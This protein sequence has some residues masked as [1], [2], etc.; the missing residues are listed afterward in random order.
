MSS[1]EDSSHKSIDK[2]SDESSD[3][4]PD[5]D[6]DKAVF[7]FSDMSSSGNITK[8]RSRNGGTPVREV[9]QPAA[10]TNVDTDA[11]QK[12]SQEKQRTSKA[13]AE[14]WS[15]LEDTPLQKRKRVSFTEL[16][17][18]QNHPLSTTPNPNSG[19]QSGSEPTPK[20][21]QK[22]KRVSF[23]GIS[24]FPKRPLTPSKTPR[25]QKPKFTPQK[26]KPR[27]PTTVTTNA[28]ANPAA[29]TYPRLPS[30]PTY[31][32]DLPKPVEPE[33][34]DKQS[35]HDL[36]EE[37]NL[38][39]TRVQA[40]EKLDET[41]LAAAAPIGAIAFSEITDTQTIDPVRETLRTVDRPAAEAC[42]VL[43]DKLTE[44]QAGLAASRVEGMEQFIKFEEADE[45]ARRGKILMERIGLL[46][47]SNE[48]LGAEKDEL[49]RLCLSRHLTAQERGQYIRALVETNKRFK[50][51]QT[52]DKVTIA[53]LQG[54]INNLNRENHGLEQQRVAFVK[55]AEVY[56]KKLCREGG[57]TTITAAEPGST[58][59]SQS[60]GYH[61]ETKKAA[62]GLAKVMDQLSGNNYVDAI[63][64]DSPFVFLLDIVREYG[65]RGG[66]QI[67]PRTNV[68]KEPGSESES[69]SESESKSESESES[70]PKPKLK[71]EPKPEPKSFEPSELDATSLTNI[72]AD[73]PC[74]TIKL[75]LRARIQR[76]QR[77][78][79]AMT[80]S[81]D[82]LRRLN[83]LCNTSNIQA[84]AAYKAQTVELDKVMHTL[85]QRETEQTASIA[86]A[87]KLRGSLEKSRASNEKARKT[88]KRLLGLIERVRIPNKSDET[89]EENQT[90]QMRI[91]LSKSILENKSQD[92]T[93]LDLN[94][95]ITTLRGNLLFNTVDM[96]TKDDLI[97]GM[98]AENLK[99]EKNSAD[100]KALHAEIASLKGMGDECGKAK[101]QL[102][103]E[104]LELQKQ[105]A[106]QVRAL[107]A[108]MKNL[109]QKKN[110]SQIQAQMDVLLEAER[111]LLKLQNSR[112]DE[113]RAVISIWEGI[114]MSSEDLA[115]EQVRQLRDTSSKKDDQIKALEVEVEGLRSALPTRAAGGG[116]DPCAHIKKQ[117][118]E[119]QAASAKKD[120]VIKDLEAEVDKMRKTL[121]AGT[122]GDGTDPCAL[123]KKQ[124]LEA[125]AASA[126]KDDL[127]KNLQAEIHKVKAKLKTP[128][129][130]DAPTRHKR[131]ILELQGRLNRVRMRL[132][133]R[134][135]AQDALEGSL[136][137]TKAL[138]A[139][140]SKGEFE[141]RLQ[142]IAT[143]QRQTY[144]KRINRLYR[145][146]QEQMFP[147]ISKADGPVGFPDT[148]LR[149]LLRQDG[150]PIKEI[151]DGWFAMQWDEL[152][153]QI[154]ILCQINY[155][156]RVDHLHYDYGKSAG[157]EE[158]LSYYLR[159]VVVSESSMH[160][161]INSLTEVFAYTYRAKIAIAVIFRILVEEIFDPI[162]F[163][164]YMQFPDPTKW[165]TKLQFRQAFEHLDNPKFP[166]AERM[167]GFQD[168]ESWCTRKA[169]E[170]DKEVYRPR[171]HKDMNFNYFKQIEERDYDGNIGGKTSPSA[172]GFSANHAY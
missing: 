142:E 166:Q 157:R 87:A 86:E 6:P 99:L 8:G 53:K 42:L 59:G 164:L 139:A 27:T 118:L 18:A 144:I 148:S 82:G 57:A 154:A 48:V 113:L 71:F 34:L 117:L 63:V 65:L 7:T 119:T 123:V 163:M 129:G 21:S 85:R 74:R 104:L 156:A 155:R 67:P 24:G 98:R 51:I 122:P 169:T 69:E 3:H 115:I 43:L 96:A 159:D 1:S 72:P 136:A 160:F 62:E 151:S 84:L 76:V 2:S 171:R 14:M 107:Q 50:E 81:R 55:S 39:R 152:Y 101:A 83:D 145:I 141:I 170:I 41:I 89:D 29:L 147:V 106:E 78:L 80:E 133:I 149:D 10:D 37:N 66:G 97:D 121:P 60:D 128:T 75:L 131:D 146:K 127:I 92:Q 68:K 4:V 93:I 111:R 38:L 126:K 103:K 36:A 9:L 105:S 15:V 58:A 11:E 138:V 125:Q 120:D 17:N 137:K 45:E 116:L 79:Q 168:R 162:R 5:W 114:N 91:E 40:F 124:L 64:P 44:T 108:E 30:S 88:N 150:P 47:E 172:S 158:L 110:V 33:P 167:R 52:G 73:D 20:P 153:D 49:T 46:E 28:T 61:E 140:P 25:N 102:Q 32:S 54:E 109:G 12:A 165:K 143:R 112:I 95:E 23:A 77:E 31:H 90:R 13:A 16:P 56:I 35:F 135:Q 100:T 161:R 132:K 130:D 22:K 134:K 94:N 19:K 70:E 26:K